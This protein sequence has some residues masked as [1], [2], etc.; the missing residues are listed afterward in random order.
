MAVIRHFKDPKNRAQLKALP[1][2]LFDEAL[3]ERDALVQA[4]VTAEMAL[5]IQIVLVAPMR[6]ANLAALHLQKNMVR[7]GGLVPTYHLII[8]PE[9]VKNEEPL[10]Y[11]LPK[12]VN[13]MLGIYLPRKRGCK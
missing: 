1:G 2:R 4:A 12:I 13:E 10:E 6:L 11:P 3:A 8:P 7:V 9:D 5:A